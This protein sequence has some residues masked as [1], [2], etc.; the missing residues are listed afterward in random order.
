MI[1]R[2]GEHT[3]LG[4]D[5]DIIDDNNI[6]IGM[7]RYIQEAIYF[8]MRTCSQNHSLQKIKICTKLIHPPPTLRN[9]QEEYFRSI[10]ANILWTTKRSWPDT[11]AAVDFICTQVKSPM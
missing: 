5:I 6:T 4:M 3:L 10:V 2:G 9:N 8:L 11:E 7:K 1:T